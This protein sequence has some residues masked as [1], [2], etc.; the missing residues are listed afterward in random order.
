MF[1][2]VRGTG[3]PFSSCQRR[4]GHIL[5]RSQ[6][7]RSSRAAPEVSR[8]RVIKY[9]VCS[10]HGN[11]TPATDSNSDICSLQTWSVVHS[12]TLH[13]S[14]IEKRGYCH[15]DNVLPFLKLCDDAEFLLRCGPCENNFFVLT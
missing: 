9:H 12:I 13:V 14:T 5:C 1:R 3:S 7:W 11:I 2:P 8:R 4:A 6:Y 10:F 15:S